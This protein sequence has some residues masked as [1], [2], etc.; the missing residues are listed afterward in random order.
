MGPQLAPGPAV[1]EGQEGAQ[2][3]EDHAGTGDRAELREEPGGADGQSGE[4]QGE[5]RGF[6]AEGHHPLDDRGGRA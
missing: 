4:D 1:E 6:P 2:A 3:G 5:D